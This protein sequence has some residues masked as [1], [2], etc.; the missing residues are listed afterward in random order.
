MTPF[1]AAAQKE[2][3]QVDPQVL[4][5]ALWGAASVFVA[6]LALA[7]LARRWWAR[8]QLAQSVQMNVPD[9]TPEEIL[10]AQALG[11]IPPG[12]QLPPSSAS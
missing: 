3:D 2:G 9:P 10:E 7:S 6:W 12:Q 8:R 1:R 4:I 11:L 5:V